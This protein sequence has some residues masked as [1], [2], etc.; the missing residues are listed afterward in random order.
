MQDAPER[1]ND[2]GTC[3]ETDTPLTQPGSR[4]VRYR[5]I[6]PDGYGVG[7]FPTATEAASA[8][9]GFWPGVGQDETNSGFGWD[10]ETV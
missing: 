9:A 8:A 10:I 1:M 7:T 2:K 5:L 6:S 4:P 3:S